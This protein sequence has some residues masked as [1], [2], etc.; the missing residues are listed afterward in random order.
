MT[1]IP[2]PI[3]PRLIEADSVLARP[4]ASPRSLKVIALDILIHQAMARPDPIKALCDLDLAVLRRALRLA[5]GRLKYMRG[6]FGNACGWRRVLRGH[7]PSP[8]V[9]REFAEHQVKTI[10]SSIADYR[11]RI[12]RLQAAIVLKTN[13]PA[14]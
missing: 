12:V 13:P 2:F 14:A 3:G 4:P 5:R 9:L 1:V 8:A 11:L 7:A 10:K 6:S